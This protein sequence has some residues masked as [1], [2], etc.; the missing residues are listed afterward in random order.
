MY[1]LNTCF[2]QVPV[3]IFQSYKVFPDYTVRLGRSRPTGVSSRLQ[4]VEPV[5]SSQESQL[6]PS[7]L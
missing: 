6:S 3:P 1:R 4:H 2:F 7:G 5:D